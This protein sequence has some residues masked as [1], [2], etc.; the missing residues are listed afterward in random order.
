MSYWSENPELYDEIIINEA[1]NKGLLTKEDFEE[2]SSRDIIEKL[3]KRPD[4]YK[5][6]IAAEREFWGSKIDNIMNKG[7]G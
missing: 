6:A 3:A 7:K 2:A 4:F 1:R 5:I